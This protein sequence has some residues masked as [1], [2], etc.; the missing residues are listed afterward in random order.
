MET[1]DVISI[2]KELISLLELKEE[3][4]FKIR[5]YDK[6]ID[7]LK[8]LSLNLEEIVEKFNSKVSLGFGPQIIKDILEIHNT[9]T[10][11]L[12]QT[13]LKEIPR[14]QL[15][16]LKIKGLGPKKVI[17]LGKEKYIFTPDS[18][19]QEIESGSLGKLKGFGEKTLVALKENLEFYLESKGFFLLDAHEGTLER[20]N[21]ILNDLVTPCDSSLN[22]EETFT[23]VSLAT[24]AKSLDRIKESLNAHQITHI[25][26]KDTITFSLREHPIVID[27]VDDK[28]YSTLRNKFLEHQENIR[29]IE[30]SLKG[31][32]HMHSTYSDGVHTIKELAEEAIKLGYS[33]IGISDHSQSA[34]YAG[35]LKPQDIRSQ[36]LE[37]D[38]LN[39]ELTPFKIFKGI[40]SD[41]LADGS[42][43][44]SEEVLKTFDFVIASVHSGFNMTEEEMTK[45]II[46]AVRN[47]YTTI[48]GHPTG[49]LL[50]QRKGYEVNI[51]E[52]LKVAE[53][54]GVIV[55]IN[56]NPK[57]LDV[58]W[59]EIVKNKNLILAITSDAHSKEQLQLVKYGAMMAFKAGVG[60]ESII[61]CLDKDSFMRL[62]ND[63]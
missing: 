61:N 2:F 22:K 32:I 3:N 1:Q 24:T 40:E 54:E 46:K 7:S 43:D 62:I 26:S 45:R 47:P 8:A 14:G 34:A 6:A 23:Q 44:Y 30:K 58:S 12:H 51:P 29:K 57:R 59:K 37:I 19:K 38:R 25:E 42:L 18:L 20:C 35:G 50:L 49:R 41:I 5:A 10:L 36:H 39:K 55:E 15:E 4:P 48:L 9:H 17:Q 21:E 13:L 33:Y 11:A 60:L 31:S 56:S 27:T 16:L 28:S 53:E 52:I 63:I